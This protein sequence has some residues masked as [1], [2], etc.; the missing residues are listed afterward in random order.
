M[1]AAAM[2]IGVQHIQ[3]PCPQGVLFS[4]TGKKYIDNKLGILSGSSVT[5]SLL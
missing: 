1:T 5:I 3:Y 4:N 2:N